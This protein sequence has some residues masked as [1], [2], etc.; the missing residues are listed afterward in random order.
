[1]RALI[2]AAILLN[3]TLAAKADEWDFAAQHKQHC[4]VGGQDVMNVC[5]ANAYRDTNQRLSAL[6][7]QLQ[8][9]LEDGTSLRK[10]Q[11]T[12]LRFR[13]QTCEY[14]VSGLVKDNAGLYAYAKHACMIDITEKRIR[15]LKEYLSWDCNG[16]PGRK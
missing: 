1:M 12:W 11:A 15:D 2:F 3:T 4:S 8:V 14:E 16:C 6:Y 9:V 10:A 13:D 5:L 7:E